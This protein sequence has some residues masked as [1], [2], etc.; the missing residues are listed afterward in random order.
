MNRIE[1]YLLHNFECCYEV[2]ARHMVDHEVIYFD[3]LYVEL[4]DGTAIIYDDLDQTFRN[5]SSFDELTR[6]E[7]SYEFGRRL[8][9]I[10]RLRKLTQS[11]LSDRTGITQCMLSRYMNGKANPSLHNSYVLARELDV[12]IH[13]LC[14][15]SRLNK[16]HDER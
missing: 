6:Y 3:E 7:S 11:E 8:N 5:I 9:K 16:K 4:D 1:E 2:L 15:Y 14:F 10:M 12:D 13:D